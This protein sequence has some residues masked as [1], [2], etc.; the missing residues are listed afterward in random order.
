MIYETP[1]RKIRGF[2]SPSDFETSSYFSRASRLGQIAQSRAMSLISVLVITGVLLSLFVLT[3]F[4]KTGTGLEQI[5]LFLF[6]LF[7]RCSSKFLKLEQVLLFIIK[8]LQA[9]FV[10]CSNVPVFFEDKGRIGEFFARDEA[11]LQV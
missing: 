8:D 3:L 9:F 7:Q 10:F 1:S 6:R 11:F 4:Q 5:R 2:F